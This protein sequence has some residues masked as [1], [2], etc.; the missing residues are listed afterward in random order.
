MQNILLKGRV[1]WQQTKKTSFGEL[2]SVGMDVGNN[3]GLFLTINN[4]FDWHKQIQKGQYLIVVK[5]S[6]S[7]KRK[8]EDDPLLN[9][10]S[11][12]GKDVIRVE[13]AEVSSEVRLIGEYLKGENMAYLFKTIGNRNPKTDKPTEREVVVHMKEFNGEI[14]KRYFICADFRGKSDKSRDLFL[15]GDEHYKL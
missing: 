6:I 8:T 12:K 11:A 2:V 4:P 13:K 9:N 3:A 7:A 5:G 10:V 1:F 15:I 14:G